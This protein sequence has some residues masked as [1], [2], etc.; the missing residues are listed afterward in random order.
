VDGAR[1]LA[2]R[3]VQTISNTPEASDSHVGAS[4]GFALHPLHGETL[5]GLVFTAD[6][7]L[8]AVKASGKGSARVARVV[9][10][11]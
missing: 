10:A 1:T 6:S 3:F 4:A 8:M 11:V 9:S 5:D 2:E 7:A